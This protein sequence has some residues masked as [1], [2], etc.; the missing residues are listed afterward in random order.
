MI[1][2]QYAKTKKG[3]IIKVDSLS[4]NKPLEKYYCIGCENELIPRLGNI[5]V[6]HFA[7]KEQLNCSPETYLHRLGKHLFLL[8]YKGCLNSSK[9]YKLEYEESYYCNFFEKRFCITCFKEKQ[10]K[11]FDLT[12]HFTKI[13]LEKKDG[14]LIPDLR[15]YNPKTNE[16]IYIEIAVTH[17]VEEQKESSGNRIIE[18]LIENEEDL[19]IL[20]STKIPLFYEKIIRYNFKK[21]EVKQKSCYGNCNTSKITFLAYRSGKTILKDLKLKDLN[22]LIEKKTVIDFKIL[23]GGDLYFDFRTNEYLKNVIN[24]FE[25]G[26]KIKNCFLCR[27]HAINKNKFTKS[28]KPIFCKFLKKAYTSNQAA[29]CNFYKPDK[30]VYSKYIEN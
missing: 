20:T 1:K 12:K 4:R 6:K 18:F 29:D 10:T 21:S 2:Y 9:P 3:E 28:E 22:K 17:Q 30:K 19:S 5:R 15:V 8:T 27:Y 14:N 25:K 26:I 13:E 16:S 24:S 11:N 23:Q 7:H